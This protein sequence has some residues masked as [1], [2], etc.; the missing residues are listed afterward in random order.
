MTLLDVDGGIGGERPFTPAG[1]LDTSSELPSRS[2]T[3]SNKMF[4]R[5]G[6]AQ[7]NLLVGFEEDGSDEYSAS[8]EMMFSQKWAKLT[9]KQEPWVAK[10][11]RPGYSSSDAMLR[12][13]NILDHKKE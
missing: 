12:E 2:Q 5:S 11:A 3:P 10:W 1:S 9:E 4:G 8:Q 7:R 6:T 13:Q